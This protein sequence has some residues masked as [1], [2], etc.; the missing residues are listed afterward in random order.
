MQNRRSVGI[1]PEVVDVSEEQVREEE[2]I[3]GAHQVRQQRMAER[4]ERHAQVHSQELMIDLLEEAVDARNLEGVHG[5]AEH[6]VGRLEGEGVEL[7]RSHRR[8]QEHRGM[9]RQEA[10]VEERVRAGESLVDD[11]PARH[12]EQ[13]RSEDQVVGVESTP[14]HAAGGSGSLGG[15]EQPPCR[16]VKDVKRDPGVHRGAHRWAATAV[17][18]RGAADQPDHDGGDQAEIESAINQEHRPELQF[19]RALIAARSIPAIGPG[20]RSAH[21]GHVHRRIRPADDPFRELAVA[22]KHGEGL[23]HQKKD[24]KDEQAADDDP[25]RRREGDPWLR[26]WRRGRGPRTNA[27]DHLGE[28]DHV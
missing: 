21:V 5:G 24:G 7:S 11:E 17:R 16:N 15:E 2:Q 9:E 26:A 22:R 13:E 10:Q 3:A 14:A 19:P 1:A 6:E 23:E 12:Q 25:E 8:G 4:L 28:A 27:R 18:W 20:Q